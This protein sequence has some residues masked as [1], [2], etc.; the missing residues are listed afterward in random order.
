[1]ILSS[2]LKYKYISI[3]NL[4]VTIH[5]T[6]YLEYVKAFIFNT[7]LSTYIDLKL[8]NGSKPNSSALLC[9]KN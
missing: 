3:Y 8:L 4:R 9:P 6:K 5:I 7:Y 1:M 2:L